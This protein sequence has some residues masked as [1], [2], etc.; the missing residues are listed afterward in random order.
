MQVMCVD[1]KTRG[2]FGDVPRCIFLSGAEVASTPWGLRDGSCLYNDHAGLPQVYCISRLTTY[3]KHWK[4]VSHSTSKGNPTQAD[5]S[6][7]EWMALLR[8]DDRM[9]A[10]F[11]SAQRS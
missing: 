7:I 2:P 4:I 5:V 3:I 8:C 9:A 6:E 1:I 10:Q 11:H